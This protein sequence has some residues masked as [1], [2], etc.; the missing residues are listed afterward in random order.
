MSNRIPFTE[1]RLAAIPL[2]QAGRTVYYDTEQPGL[3]VRVSTTGSKT[4]SVLRRS[5]GGR[6]ERI[7]IGKWPD[8]SVKRAREEA[9]Q[10][11][12]ALARA[13][14]PADARRLLRA[15]LT[16]GELFEK[17]IA[18]R[19]SAGKRS[20]AAL[21]A[22]WEL[23]VGELPARPRK[24]HG[25]E[26]SKPAEGV[27]WST[28]RISEIT[29]QQIS[30][31]HARIATS[32]KTITANRV[33]ELLRAMWGYAIRQKI[34]SENPAD[35]I[36]P[37]KEKD[38]SRFLGR[39][40]LPVFVEAL[41]HEQQPWQDYFTLLLYVGYRRAAV[42]AI[43]WQDVDLLAGTWTVPG[44]RAKNGD[45]IVLPLVGPALDTLKVRWRDRESSVWVFPGGSTA[46]HLTQPKKA[47]T[48]LLKR[49]GLTNLRMHDLRRTLG[50]WLAMSGVSLL[51]IGQVLGHKDQRST[52]VYAR[53]QAD[54]AARAV[55]LAHKTMRAA[56]RA[57]KV[58]PLPVRR[59]A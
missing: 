41:K 51:A 2:P 39:D 6:P 57:P 53:L 20:V 8:L 44:E 1:A 23:Y 45:P 9:K 43:R 22:M 54:T 37:T 4:F 14:S 15:E 40:A 27:N 24:K 35:G 11:V 55:S 59:G 21:R 47:W 17:Y 33:H 3:Q 30:T 18:D 29:T 46:G 38:R 16:L 31:L 25:R 12:A 5:R 48:R 36:T 50:S 34:A 10:I 19:E 28:R 58:V 32:G 7:N 26:R 13:Q 52:Q 56:L 42:A 49:A